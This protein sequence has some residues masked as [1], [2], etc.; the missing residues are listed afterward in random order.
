MKN[1][2]FVSKL[3]LLLI[4]VVLG[5]ACG[6]TGSITGP[7]PEPTPTAH[8]EISFKV[9]DEFGQAVQIDA[10]GVYNLQ[11]GKVQIDFAVPAGVT[12]SGKITQWGG[13]GPV[14]NSPWVIVY[15][16]G[17]WPN[18]QTPIIVDITDS[19]G[20]AQ[21]KVAMINRK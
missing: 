14:S 1:L 13:Y 20:Y 17:D 6:K 5:A 18:G 19:T 10:N 8:V 15:V 21:Q 3:A 2:N 16:N 4:L 7:S 9:F 12:F 11:T